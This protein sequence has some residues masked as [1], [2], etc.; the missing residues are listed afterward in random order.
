MG[1]SNIGH[2]TL[3]TPTR[4]L[5]LNNILHVPNANKS[6]AC[7]HRIA[8]D[9]NAFLEFHPIFF[10][11]KDQATITTLHRGRCSGRLY[12]LGLSREGVNRSKQALRVNKPST[13]R[14]HSRLG[15]PAFPIVSR[16]LRDNETSLC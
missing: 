11:I 9:N 4:D 13:S 16:V 10:L 7:V 1:I 3:H 12:P 6:L 8:T 5:H 2:T 15:H 14:W